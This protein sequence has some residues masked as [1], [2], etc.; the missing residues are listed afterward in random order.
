MFAIID[1]N[2]LV[3]GF[4]VEGGSNRIAITNE[5]YMGQLENIGLYT[6]ADGDFTREDFPKPELGEADLREIL[7]AGDREKERQG[8]LIVTKLLT[9]QASVNATPA[10]I[11][12]MSIFYPS[13]ES[14]IGKT[15]T[16]NN[17]PYLTDNGKIFMLVTGHTVAKHWKPGIGTES[18]FSE[19]PKPGTIANWVQPLGAHDTYNK[20]GSG[21]PKSD[22]VIFT[23]KIWESLQNNNSQTPSDGGYW[24]EQV[25]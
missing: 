11:N 2:N 12:K 24:K 3:V 5:Q 18:L 25:K 22:P 8:V 9:A 7:I 15:I 16:K 23:G 14:L 10:Q 20:F 13:W 19:V 21:L 4:D 6:Y 17:T 1:G